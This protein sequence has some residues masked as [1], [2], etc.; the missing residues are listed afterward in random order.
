[1]VPD[2]CA[3]KAALR[4]FILSFREQLKFFKGPKINL[5]EI[6]TPLVQT[7]LHNRQPGWSGDFNPGMPVTDFVSAVLDGFKARQETIAVGLAKATWDEFE[8]ARGRRV[9]PQWEVIRKTMG[10]AHVLE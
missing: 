9:G 7:E 1:M 4:S 8:E 5:V 3:S 2:Y 6:Y 10:S